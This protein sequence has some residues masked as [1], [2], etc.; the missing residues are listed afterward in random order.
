MDTNNYYEK[1]NKF[2]N[3]IKYDNY[4]KNKEIILETLKLVLILIKNKTDI[5]FK[6]FYDKFM[7]KLKYIYEVNYFIEHICYYKNDI[8][9]YIELQKYLSFIILNYIYKLN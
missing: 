2:Y 1:V 5:E 8:K 9:F 6:L 7:L 4:Y 3:N